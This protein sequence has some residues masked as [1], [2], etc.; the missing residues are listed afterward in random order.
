MTGWKKHTLLTPV[1]PLDSSAA[2]CELEWPTVKPFG[3]LAPL[4]TIVLSAH[5][6]L[7]NVST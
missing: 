2:E 6:L 7:L 4:L 5:T 1:S 3:K